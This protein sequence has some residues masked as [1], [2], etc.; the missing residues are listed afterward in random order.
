MSF[1]Q[2]YESISQLRKPR[3]SEVEDGAASPKTSQ[4]MNAKGSDL[5]WGPLGCE[6]YVLC[7]SRPGCLSA[8]V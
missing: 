5:D 7:P 6:G 1:H 8:Q 2:D 3:L 4:L